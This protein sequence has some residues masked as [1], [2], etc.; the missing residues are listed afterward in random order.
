M[1]SQVYQS[2]MAVVLQSGMPAVIWWQDL[3]SPT[4][5]G[6]IVGELDFPAR[7]QPFQQQLFTSLLVADQHEFYLAQRNPVH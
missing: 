1:S 5:S 2:P 4:Q 6:V 3:P 7:Q